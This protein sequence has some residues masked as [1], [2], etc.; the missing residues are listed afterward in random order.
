MNRKKAELI[1]D[2]LEK[3]YPDADCELEFSSPYQLL[4]AVMLSAQCTDKRVNIVTRELF[5]DYGTPEKMI[6]LT[7]SELEQKIF[8]CGFYKN[9]AKNILETTDIILKRYNG[10][11]PE[12]FEELREL[13]GVGRKTANVVAAIA[14]SR[15]AIAVD[16]HVFRVS[17]RIGLAK[18]KNVL[19][20]ELQLQKNLPEN[21]WIKAHHAI[22]WHGRR[23]CSSQKPKCETCPV[24]KQ[25]DY[26][27]HLPKSK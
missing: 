20:T 10:N 11:V 1:L 5:K 2:E 15:P 16:T 23:C 17:N 3:L 27:R 12:N 18:A 8:S 7:Q 24:N 26:F 14:F 21:R 13:P 6:T 9:K 22:L 4:V 19:D 25:C